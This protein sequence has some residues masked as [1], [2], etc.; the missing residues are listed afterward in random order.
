MITSA[1]LLGQPF[2]CFSRMSPSFMRTSSGTTVT[3]RLAAVRT[4]EMLVSASGFIP[5]AI[6]TAARRISTVYAVANRAS[7][8]GFRFS[9]QAHPNPCASV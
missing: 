6:G 2:V 3:G 9:L 8:P 7:F 1:M 4:I 5:I